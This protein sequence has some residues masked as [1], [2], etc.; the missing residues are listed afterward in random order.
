MSHLGKNFGCFA[1]GLL[2]TCGKQVMKGVNA[3]RMFLF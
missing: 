1:L 2:V 3:T